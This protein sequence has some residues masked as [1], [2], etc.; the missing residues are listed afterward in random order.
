MSDA[1]LNRATEEQ[2][3]SE[4]GCKAMTNTPRKNA[5][6]TR[7]RPFAEGNPGRPPGARHKATLAIEALLEGEAE[8]I[9][10]TCIARALGGDSVALRLVMERIA[11]VRRGR[12]VTFNLPE[13]ANARDVV[14]AIGCVLRAVADGEITPDEGTL[15]ANVLEIKRRA[16]ETVEIE[17]RVRELEEKRGLK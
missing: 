4:P 6:K 14:S 11:P 12:P 10:R 1:R 16:I 2:T 15:V 8:T 13:V 7:G 17:A 5:S 9:G 3:Q